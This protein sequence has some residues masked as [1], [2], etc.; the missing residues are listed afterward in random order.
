M[1]SF[2][3]KGSPG[4]G[5]SGVKWGIT[6]IVQIGLPSLGVSSWAAWLVPGCAGL[7]HSRAAGD[8]TCWLGIQAGQSAGRL[9]SPGE[10]KSP[11]LRH[12]SCR[13]LG[14]IPGLPRSEFQTWNLVWKSP[15]S[16]IF[17][18]VKVGFLTE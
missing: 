4:T 2:Y 8:F 12:Q 15:M 17:S 9:E 11:H 1:G 13:H 16:M 18:E 5:S 14:F 7:L 10:R 6:F 3:N